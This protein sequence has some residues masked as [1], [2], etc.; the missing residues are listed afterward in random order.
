MA[1]NHSQVLQLRNDL[2]PFLIHL[3]RTGPVT[4]RKELF[5]KI[6]QDRKVYHTDKER[7]EFILRDKCIR[8][9]SPYGIFNYLVPTLYPGGF[10]SNPG[11]NVQRQW[12]RAACFTETPL[13]HIQIQT[14]QIWGRNL[15]FGPYGLAF[16]E[17]FIRDRGGSPVFYFASDLPQIPA[18]IKAMAFSADAQKFKET[19]PYYESF[20]P[21][22]HNQGAP[23]DFRWEREWRTRND[24][25]FE[26]TDIAF[27]LCAA[28]DIPMFS[29]LVGNAFPFV[30]PVGNAAHIQTI[31][32]HLRTFP[33]L[34]NLK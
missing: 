7:L 5:P 14:N 34:A 10:T 20:G 23:I 27:G 25:T 19:F 17:Q 4:I 33:H 29:N 32:T 3:T 22:L 16:Q 8:A 9:I 13:D 2:S 1:L 31:K 15:Q 11:S 21:R 18:A 26:Y 30:D 28:A 12:L 24:V 6:P